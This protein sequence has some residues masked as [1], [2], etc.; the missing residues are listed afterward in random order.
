MWYTANTGIM[1]YTSSARF[2]AVRR[3]S[4]NLYMYCRHVETYLE[5][6]CAY[7][8]LQEIT[9]LQEV[10]LPVSL[11]VCPHCMHLGVYSIFYRNLHTCIQYT[12]S[13]KHEN[14]RCALLQF[15]PLLSMQPMY[16]LL[17][18]DVSTCASVFLNLYMIR[19]RQ[20]QRCSHTTGERT[21]VPKH[22]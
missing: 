20:H 21:C 12:F 18:N 7:K 13:V 14:Y 2:C 3:L 17:M 22:Q 9:L 6:Y 19:C 1:D 15:I 10:T 8:P 4:V 16:Q 5:V 11:S